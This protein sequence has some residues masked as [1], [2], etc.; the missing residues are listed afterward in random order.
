LTQIR[1]KYLYFSEQATKRVADDNQFDLDGYR[2]IP[3]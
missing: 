3:S 1:G 2:R